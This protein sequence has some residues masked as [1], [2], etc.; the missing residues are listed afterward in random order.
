MLLPFTNFL[1]SIQSWITT[2]FQVEIVF[3]FKIKYLIN[4]L[5]GIQQKK[6]FV[7]HAYDKYNLGLRK[8][9]DSLCDSNLNSCWTSE[10]VSGAFKNTICKFVLFHVLEFT[11]TPILLHDNKK[12]FVTNHR[13]WRKGNM[14]HESPDMLRTDA[15]ILFWIQAAL[16]DLTEKSHCD[17]WLSLFVKY[18]AYWPRLL[19]SLKM[20]LKGQ[21]FSNSV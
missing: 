1:S 17:G 5:S 13:A 8:L 4:Y 16:I 21:I 12:S 10:C 2:L 3:S 9:K 7:S 11:Q 15:Q 18:K 6:E 14:F 20:D 19:S